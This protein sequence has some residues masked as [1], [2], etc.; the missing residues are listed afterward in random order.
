MGSKSPWAA[1]QRI[2]GVRRGRGSLRNSE[3][4]AQDADVRNWVRVSWQRSEDSHVDVDRPAFTFVSPD[5]H[6]STL[7]RAAMP[8]FESLS[9]E[10]VNEPACL[11]LTDA[12]G[13]VLHRGGGDGSLIKALDSVDLAPGFKYSEDQVGTN[14]IGTALE[15]GA[16]LLVDGDEHY[17]GCLRMF[18]CAGALITHPVTGALLG[19]VDITTK[20]K[21]SNP[22][23]LSFAKLAAKRIQ[24]RILEE[25][26]QLD[27]ALLSDYYAACRHTGGSVIAIGGEVFMMNEVTQ[28]HFDAN[29]QAALIDQ[30]RDVRGRSTP[31][32]LLA[33]LPSGITTRLAYQP[34]FVGAHLAGGIVQVKEQHSGR[35][36]SGGSRTPLAGLAGSSPQWRHLTQGVLSARKHSEWLV[37]EGEPGIGKM[38]VLRAAQL[39]VAPHRRLAIL[40]SPEEATQEF[41]DRA[42]AELH[43]G[44]DLVISH[45][46]RL[47][48]EARDGLAE[49]LQVVRDAAVSQ[50]PWIALT[51]QAEE[52]DDELAAQLLRFFPRTV[53]VPP[54]RHHVEDI[55][56]LVRHL[57]SKAG[58]PGLMLSG[59][60]MNQ[61]MR[62]PWPGNVTQLRGVL[63]EVS[64]RRRSG[65]VEAAELPPQCQ[66]T[67]RRHL[68]KMEALERDAIVAALAAHG[69]DKAA[70]AATLGMSRATIYRKIRGYGV[71]C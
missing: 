51:V 23:L 2:E 50:D 15:V 55:P 8:I 22:L 36:A 57:L 59:S 9:Q 4:L 49:I 52:I 70:A 1:G 45:A 18:S 66:A 19:V 69:G 43:S 34:T 71:V 53:V 21:N 39:H 27:H 33:D 48:A 62:L 3:E 16:P 6:E 38:A 32:M 30:T 44:A 56:E 46:H 26:N 65:V 31:C 5:A 14:G 7:T 42:Q 13:T 11:I 47:P 24:E 54:L 37:L 35:P 68:T 28:Q 60:A 63:V 29:D 41:L 67:T 20:A 40:D 58:V 64:H 12:K 61:L 10:L 25:A 17:A